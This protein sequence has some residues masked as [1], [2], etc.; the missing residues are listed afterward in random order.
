M[1]TRRATATFASGL[2][3]AA[4]S[5]LLGLFATPFILHAL[6]A[7]R[8]GAFRALMELVGYLSLLELGQMSA[9]QIAFARAHGEGDA[10]LEE[11]AFA[12]GLRRYALVAL[13]G[14]AGGAI[15]FPL[16][17]RFVPVSEA[18][19][20]DRAL[21][22]VALVV[23][24]ATVPAH[25]LR[26]YLDAN[27]RG[28]AGN[29]ALMVQT[30]LV[31]S[32]S[33][34]FS[35]G[36]GGITGQGAAVAIGA[37]VYAAGLAF[38]CRARLPEALRAALRRQSPDAEMERRIWRMNLPAFAS[39]IAGRVCVLSDN[40]V[41][42]AVL[43]PAAVVP[44]FLTQRLPLLAQ[45]QLQGIGNSVWAGLSELHAKGEMQLFNQRVEQV[46]K[47]IAVLGAGGLAALVAANRTFVT[48]WVGADNFGGDLLTAISAL[49]AVLISVLSL[50]GWCF[51]SAGDV[52]P[53]TPMMVVQA[54]VNLAASVAF[55]HMG[56]AYG[57]AL[58]SLVAF[59]VVPSWWIPRLMKQN[60]QA[61][62]FRLARAALGPVLVGAVVAVLLRM[63]LQQLPPLGWPGLI[64]F[65]GIAGPVSLLVVGGATCNAGDRA[66]ALEK[67]KGLRGQR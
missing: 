38:A 24:F 19:A 46:T 59:A 2:G 67:L 39:G 61:D 10:Q 26:A 6:G 18:L 5:S 4:I 49:N 1:R 60:F 31:I 64:I 21:G 52:R 9:L 50:W 23:G 54:V 56:W 45:S 30:A 28:A 20:G 25:V 7:E 42:S 35:M 65:L 66:F 51:S 32:L 37:V 62:W 57:P 8:L 33:V 27:Q 34:V 29:V 11:T 43:G 16:L 15:L 48:L 55:T 14:V 58:G 3:I 12:S 17:G 40:L 13:S 44:F 53:L 36:G 63:A 22:F 47:L 41:L